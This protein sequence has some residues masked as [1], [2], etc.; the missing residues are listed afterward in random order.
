MKE[1]SSRNKEIQNIKINLTHVYGYH[2]KDNHNNVKYI[3]QNSI[4]F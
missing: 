4:I 1:G 2:P 3:T